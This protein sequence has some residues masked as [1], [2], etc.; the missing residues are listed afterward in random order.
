MRTEDVLAQIDGALSDWDVGPD[1]MRCNASPEH[2]TEASSIYTPRSCP[3][4]LVV[5]TSRFNEAMR[6]WI[7]VLA[8]V[9]P[10]LAALL[11]RFAPVAP[12]DAHHPAPLAID[13]H[14]YRR[15]VRRRSGR[16]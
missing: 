6:R 12:Y 3:V 11:E 4:H 8:E 10:K 16:P 1:A 15:R 14:A 13:G 5:D 9:G 7:A 2:R